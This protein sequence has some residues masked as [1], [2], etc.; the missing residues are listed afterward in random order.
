MIPSLVFNITRILA[1][2][3]AVILLFSTLSESFGNNLYKEPM[4][5]QRFIGFVALC[6]IG[7]FVSLF[8]TTHAMSK[9]RYTGAN[10]E[11]GALLAGYSDLK[12]CYSFNRRLPMPSLLG[13]SFVMFAIGAAMLLMPPTVTYSPLGWLSMLHFLYTV[14]TLAVGYC[15]TYTRSG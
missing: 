2:I 11:C 1:I 12:F 3:Y 8:A 5:P 4:E 13:H 10:N 7:L 15:N 6:W 14:A 9:V